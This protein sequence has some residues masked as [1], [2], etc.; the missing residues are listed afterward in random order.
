M[1]KQHIIKAINDCNAGNMNFNDRENLYCF[2]FENTWFPLRA[3][4]NYASLMANE[5]IEY[6]KNDALVKMHEL[7]DYIKVKQITVQN[8]V[9]AHLELK[10]N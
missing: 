8:N 10:R 6:T 3:I 9:L 1:E 2:L 7:F 5:N 4:V